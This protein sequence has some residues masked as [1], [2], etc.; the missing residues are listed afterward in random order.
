[1]PD[2]LAGLL[3]AI[4]L[5]VVAAD[6]DGNVTYWSRGAAALY[7]WTAED[8]LGRSI[9]DVA[10]ALDARA[11][12]QLLAEVEAGN[13]GQGVF[14][15]RRKDGSQFD[16][17]VT[18]SG[19]RDAAG[20]LVG[21]VAVSEDVTQLH[22]HEREFA[23]RTERLELALASGRMGTWRW[24]VASGG[25]SWDE[26][27]ERLFGLPAGS[28]DRTFEQYAALIHPDDRE[29]VLS[30]ISA[31]LISGSEYEVEH[32]LVAPDGSV[33]WIGGAGRVVPGPLGEPVAMIGVAA[34]ITGRKEAEAERA[35]LLTA[36]RSAHASAAAAGARLAFLAAAGELLAE[37]LDYDETLERVADLVVSR[38]ADWCTIDLV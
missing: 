23:E 37:T 16:A 20:D 28:Y 38:L 6:R 30:A 25:I 14:A 2:V 21:V 27:L 10:P 31:A 18:L 3:D 13:R 1:M 8:C 33:R 24:D 26:T 35:A 19:M 15:V 5:A 12:R 7:G 32:R 17:R 11:A 29:A 36:E 9:V 34:D 4:D 22:E